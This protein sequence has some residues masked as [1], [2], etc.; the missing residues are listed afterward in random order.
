MPEDEEKKQNQYLLTKI[1]INLV[2]N[3][4]FSTG[5]KNTLIKFQIING[6]VA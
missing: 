1:N 2:T 4:V 3:I 6:A 5:T